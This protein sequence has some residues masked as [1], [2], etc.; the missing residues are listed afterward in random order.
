VGFVGDLGYFCKACN[1]FFKLIGTPAI[2]KK[3]E[4]REGEETLVEIVQKCPSCGEVRTY[5]PY[6]AIL[7][8]RELA[9]KLGFPFSN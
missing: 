8:D 3:Y 9:T 4:V 2:S 7:E 1:G 5:A 6:E